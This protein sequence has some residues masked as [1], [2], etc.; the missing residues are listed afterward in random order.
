MQDSGLLIDVRSP[1][2]EDVRGQLNRMLQSR[3]FRQSPRLS[4][5]FSFTVEQTLEG[6]EQRLKEYCLA[7]E[8]F[9]KPETFDPRMD[10][11]V[12]VAARQLRAKIDLYYLTDGAQDPVLIRYRPGDYTPRFYYRSEAPADAA[13]M[14]AHEPDVQAPPAVVVEKDR[15]NIRAVTDCLDAMSYP[16]AAVVDSGEKAVELVHDGGP[17]VVLT[18]LNL[19]GSMNGTELTRALHQRDEA[20]VV[21]IVPSTLDGQLLQQLLNAEPDAIVYEPVRAPDVR[22]ALRI[23]IARRNASIRVHAA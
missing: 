5:F 12:R 1:S 23:A 6:S 19:T 7:L 4:R 9:S 15:M 14:F 13:G 8:V 21:A 11:A 10:S 2:P 20:A 22:T 18:G 17:C 3:Y 16:I